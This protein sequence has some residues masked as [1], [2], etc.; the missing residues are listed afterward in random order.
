MIA[1]EDIIIC[2]QDLKIFGT[3][4]I[5]VK[6]SDNSSIYL[7]SGCLLYQIR[8]SVTLLLLALALS[9][10]HRPQLIKE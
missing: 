6:V 4:A 7:M 10:L 5:L 1:R 3:R 2:Q 9:L 8:M